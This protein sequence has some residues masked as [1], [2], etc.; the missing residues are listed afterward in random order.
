MLEDLIVEFLN[1][2]YN[3]RDILGFYGNKMLK[4]TQKIEQD[5]LKIGVLEIY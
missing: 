3:P 5:T 4:H 2:S 1:Q